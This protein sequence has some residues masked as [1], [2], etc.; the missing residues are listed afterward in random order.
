METPS[1]TPEQVLFRCTPDEEGK[2]YEYYA[3][4]GD[5][6]YGGK[7]EDGADIG[8]PDAYATYFKGLLIRVTNTT[9]GEAYSRYWKA[10][11]FTDLD[12][13]GKGWLLVKA[14][15]F[16]QGVKIELFRASNNQ[17]Y[18]KSNAGNYSHSQ[19]AAYVAFKGGGIGNNLSPGADSENHYDGWY[20][21]WPGAVN[22]Y[23]HVYITYSATCMVANVTPY[24]RFPTIS[25]AE[26]ASGAK[27][28]SN[29]QV[30]FNCETA[31]PDSGISA[32]KSGTDSGQTAMG[33]LPDAENVTTAINEGFGTS[34]GGVSYLLSDGY[35]TDPTIATGVGI[36]ISDK[37]GAPLTLLG[38][39]GNFGNGETSGWYPV[40]DN[41]DLQGSDSSVSYYSKTLTAS[42]MQ[43]PGKTA[44]TGKVSA[45]LKV[46]IQVQ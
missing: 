22:L 17:H 18:G 7:Y 1:F 46:I 33:L 21:D 34:K 12:K 6:T 32:F 44:T 11:A 15:N 8:L 2:I 9:T 36:Q 4:N 25:Q 20:G 10:R 43:L 30:R 41:S 16:S 38:Q 40:L 23:N 14:K 39:L 37:S 5:S 45:N 24:V 19:P 42:L 26:L 31:T 35:G 29:V 13:D 3:T 27:P 28:S